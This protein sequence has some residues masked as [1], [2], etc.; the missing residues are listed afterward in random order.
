[1]SPRDGRGTR[2]RILRAAFEEFTARGFA[3]ARVDRIASGAEVNK[4]LIYR[5]FED[6]ERLFQHVLEERMARLAEI[7][8]DPERLAEAAGEFFDFHARNRDLVRLLQ[9][10]ALDFGTKPVPNEEDRRKRW[11]QHVERIEAAQRA[12]A[13]D[14]ALDPR[15]TLITLV[16]IVTFWFACPQ[17]ARMICGGDPYTKENLAR[18]RAHVVEAVRRVL[19]AR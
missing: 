8:P 19:G 4:A 3:G 13:V 2:E 16:S 5:H 14:P 1:M 6:K 12:G 11:Q 9:W 10:E 7:E 18:R 15:Q 17:S